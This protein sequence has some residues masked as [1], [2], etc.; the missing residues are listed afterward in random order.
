M[1]YHGLG[2]SKDYSVTSKLYKLAAEQ[3]LAVAQTN[4]GNLY[5][6]G[7]GFEKNI[8]DAYMWVAIGISSGH[9]EGV[10]AADII[11]KYMTPSQI[12]EA[13]RL[14]REC[15]KKNYKECST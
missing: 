5:F 10:I 2:V 8:I 12:E 4:L 6:M 14:A 13:E 1:Y 3:G 15:V 9:K 7:H 11:V